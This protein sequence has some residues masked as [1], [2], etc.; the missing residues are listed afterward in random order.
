MEGDMAHDAVRADVLTAM[1]FAGNQQGTSAAGDVAV[2][3]DVLRDGLRAASA[4]HLGAEVDAAVAEVAPDVEEYV[5]LAAQVTQDAARSGVSGATTPPRYN[6]FILSFQHLERSLGEL[7]DLV[8]Q[9]ASVVEVQARADQARARTLLLVTGAL[10]TLAVCLLS[11]FVTSRLVR[12]VRRLQGAVEAM[13]DGDLTARSGVTGRDEPGPDGAGA[14][15][16]P[17]VGARRR[18]AGHAL[19][20]GGHHQRRAGDRRQRAGR[21]GR[22]PHLAPGG[23]GVGD[24]RGGVAQRAHGR[25]RLRADGRLDPGDLPVGGRGGRRRRPRGR[26]RRDHQPHRHPGSASRAGSSATWSR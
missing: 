24:R 26:R 15:P 7:S 8:H 3:A 1:H 23:V 12:R 10:T 4:A 25:G 6:A 21:L 19:G 9:R 17:G 2:Q 11:A 14:G 20:R 13:A 16:C 22:R 18:R 5:A